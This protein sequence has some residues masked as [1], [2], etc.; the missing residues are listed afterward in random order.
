[1]RFPPARLICSRLICG[2]LMLI[3]G[4]AN[5]SPESLKSLTVT[6]TPTNIDVGGAA[7]LKA[8]A[9]LS[10]GTTQDVTSGTQWTLS[11]GS[12]AKIG[13]GILTGKSPGTVTVPGKLQCIP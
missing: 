7:V 4:C 8:A 12:L 6:A 3:A 2:L 5:P 10:D 13:S 1:M 11:D 9:H